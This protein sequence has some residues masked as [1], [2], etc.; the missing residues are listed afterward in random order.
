MQ[1]IK[2]IKRNRYWT[3]QQIIKKK[4]MIKPK[5]YNDQIKMD[6][7]NNYLNIC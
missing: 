7:N 3:D 5:K 1:K 4:N 6:N 2:K